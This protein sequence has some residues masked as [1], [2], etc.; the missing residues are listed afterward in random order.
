M[1]AIGDG[2]RGW[3]RTYEDGVGFI[4]RT[5]D[6]RENAGSNSRVPK[7]HEGALNILFADGHVNS[8]TLKRLFED[9]SD[10]ALRMW[11]RDNQPHRER[12]N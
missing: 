11:N 6:A 5:P 12:L 3:N 10:A 9:R 8:V 4:A 1:I 7:R 2:V